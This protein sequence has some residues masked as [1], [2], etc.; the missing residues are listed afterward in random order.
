VANTL[1]LLDEVTVF[2]SGLLDSGEEILNNVFKK[3]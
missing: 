1:Q 3:R 2:L